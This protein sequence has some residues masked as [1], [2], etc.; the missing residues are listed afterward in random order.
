MF[1]KMKLATKL[2]VIIGGT[3]TV[4]FI[5]L[6]F[7]TTFLMDMPKAQAVPLLVALSAAGLAVLL[8]L[9]V[10]VLRRSLRPLNMMIQAAESISVGHL[11]V[12]LEANSQDEVGALS[13]AFQNMTDNLRRMVTDV[14]YLL[15][16]L[17]EGNFKIKSRASDCYV[18]DFTEFLQAMRRLNQRMNDTLLQILLSSDQVSSGSDQVSSGAQ[19][20]SQ[21]A[22]NQASSVQQLAASINVISEQVTQMAAN[23]RQASEKANAVGQSA[24]ESN[25][26][27]SQM[28]EAMANIRHQSDEIGKI[29]KTIEDIA[30]QTNILALNAAVEAARAGAAGKGFAVVA[31]EVRNLASKSAEASKNTAALIAGSLQAVEKGTRIADETAKAL[32]SAVTGV[33]EATEII[34]MIS[35][36]A[37]GQAASVFQISQGIEE[38]S[39]VVQTNAATSEESAAASEELSAQAQ[40]LKSLVSRFNLRTDGV[41]QTSATYR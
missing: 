16:E 30:F 18:G 21:G 40:L 14:Q 17:A 20:L 39:S 5:L 37:D 32:E 33:Q 31:D 13:A 6:I 22:A 35:I 19:T 36:A 2:S 26:K 1:K 41:D 8:L 9:L 15:G 23:A 10:L 34:D 7:A 12:K 27:M 3:L 38:I 29:I 24:N 25:E 28:L 11:D 4:V